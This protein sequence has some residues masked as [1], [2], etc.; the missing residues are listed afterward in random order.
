MSK[1][2]KRC[3]LHAMGR[4]EDASIRTLTPLR[5]TTPKELLA[6]LTCSEFLQLVEQLKNPPRAGKTAVD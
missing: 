6:Q 4:D 3:F 5:G 1:L 2:R